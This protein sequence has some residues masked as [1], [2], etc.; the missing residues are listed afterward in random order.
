MMKRL[1]LLSIPFLLTAG[2]LAVFWF[3]YGIHQPQAWQPQLDKYISYKKQE[4]SAPITVQ[5]VDHATK[6]WDLIRD[7]SF[8]V[9]GDL[10]YYRTDVN[11]EQPQAGGIPLPDPPVEVYCIL[12]ESVRK[13]TEH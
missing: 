4:L 8:I 11:Y 12:L 10:A 9:Y 7:K 2:A 13:L 5:A 6:P 3:F 1:L